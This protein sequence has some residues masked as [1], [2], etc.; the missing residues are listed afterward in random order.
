M[1]YV[2]KNHFFIPYAGN[3]RSEVERIYESIK[4]KLDDIEYVVEPFCGTSAF[5]FYMSLKHPKS[6]NIFLMIIIII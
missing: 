6:L 1:I 2:K 5:S 3:K 4:D